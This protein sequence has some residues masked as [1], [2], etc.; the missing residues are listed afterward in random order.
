MT[1]R[2]IK[3]TFKKWMKYAAMSALC[4]IISYL[5]AV[6]MPDNAEGHASAVQIFH[7]IFMFVGAFGCIVTAI[8]AITEL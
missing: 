7:V 6:T 4:F 8:A 2:E 5:M 1:D 3:F